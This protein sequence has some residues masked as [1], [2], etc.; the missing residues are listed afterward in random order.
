MVI[1]SAGH[2]AKRVIAIRL[3]GSGDLTGTSHVVWQYSKGTAYV[4]SPILYEDFV[5][6]FP[7]R[8]Y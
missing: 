3:G 1:V 7:T 5:Y 6:L 8:E 2:P 4:A